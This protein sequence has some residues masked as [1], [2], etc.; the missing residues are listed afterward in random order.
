MGEGKAPKR[1]RPDPTDFDP[2]QLPPAAQVYLDVWAMGVDPE[3]KALRVSSAAAL[4]GVSVSAVK[5]WRSTYG[6]GFRRLEQQARKRAGGTYSQRL[7]REIVHNLVVPAGK[8]MA[9]ELANNEGEW[10]AAWEVLKGAG[11]IAEHVELHGSGYTAEEL[12]RDREQAL[13][14]LEVWEREHAVDGLDPGAE[15]PPTRPPAD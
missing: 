5:G 3:G 11:A 9:A 1:E 12:A 4:A 8:R 2:S 14:E 6:L 15:Q 7:A 13:A 10:R